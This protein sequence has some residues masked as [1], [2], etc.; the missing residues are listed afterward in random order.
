MRTADLV[1]ATAALALWAHSAQAATLSCP[2]VAAVT[3]GTAAVVISLQREGEEVV[4]GVQSDLAFDPAVFSLA[5][6]DCAINPAIGPGSAADKTLS[7]SVLDDPTRTRNIVVAL[8]NTNPIPDGALYTCNFAVAPDAPLGTYTLESSN[9]RASDPEGQPVPVTAA[10]CEVEVGPAPTPTATPRCT[11]DGD[12][13]A[14]QVCVNG[15]CVTATPTATPIGFCQDNDDCPPG[16]V[17]VNNR[18]VTVTPTVTPTPPGF[19]Q[20][21]GD[22]PPGQVC[23][24][25]RCV[26]VTPTRTRG[27]G[28]GGGCSCEIDSAARRDTTGGALALLLPALLLAARRRATRRR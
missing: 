15:E 11:D 4:A 24:N 13:P 2:R 3:G 12:C 14:G 6:E 23:V 10:N 19:C 25:N 26:T 9:A 18:C 27:G 21:N 5:P 20:D 7:T 28:G 16:Q 8:G 17:C 1:A 22:C